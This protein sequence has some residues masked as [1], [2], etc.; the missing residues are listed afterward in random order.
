MRY[1]TAIVLLI[2]YVV[3]TSLSSYIMWNQGI[4]Q[5]LSSE[6]YYIGAGPAIALMMPYLLPFA[7]LLWTIAGYTYSSMED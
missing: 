5:A 3:I 7:V 1:E 4:F 2:E 6:S